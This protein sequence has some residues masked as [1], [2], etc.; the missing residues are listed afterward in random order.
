[1]TNLFAFAMAVLVFANSLAVTASIQSTGGLK[2]V[3]VHNGPITLHALLWRPRGSGPFPAIL[4]NHGSGRSREDLERLG[5]YEKQAEI[6]GPA[7]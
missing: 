4:L 7:A 6:L 2:T 5:T 1:M 3:M